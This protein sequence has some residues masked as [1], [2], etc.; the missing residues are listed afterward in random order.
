MPE[1]PE[2][3]TVRRGLLQK[4]LGEKVQAVEVLRK[5]SIGHP[6]A[7]AFS[8]QLKGHVFEDVLRRGKY[9]LI[10]LD[11]GAGLG[12]HL[13]MSGRLLLL[14]DNRTAAKFLRVR[15]RLASGLE[16]RFEDM[17]V[18]G[19][20][21]YVP[22]QNSFEDVIPGLAHL[23][24]EPL[25]GLDAKALLTLFKKRTQAVKSALLDQT[26]IAGIGNIYA[27]ESLFRAG[28]HPQT[29]AGA[30]TL[31]QAER[32]VDE[33]QAVL[34]QAIKLGGSSLKDYT[35]SRGV[36][37]NYQHQA[38][39]YGRTGKPCGVCGKAI[40]R[41]KLAG[42]SSHFCP[43]CQAKGKLSRSTVRSG[44]APR[45][46]SKTHKRSRARKQDKGKSV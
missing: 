37:G 15:I 19:R 28:I 31:A 39:V 22:A 27:D 13:R 6:N 4:L 35:D 17:R 25:D 12:V 43:N 18:F 24:V 45:I 29:K 21:W 10:K 8:K 3:E 20:L 2:V 36:N 38:H 44:L 1:L 7:T 11:G 23:G 26:I 34:A 9:L 33:I 40:E 5:E 41:V 30:V 32:L 42:R 46:D 14:E 16:L